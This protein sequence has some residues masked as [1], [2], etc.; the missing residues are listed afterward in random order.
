MLFFFILGF[1]GFLGFG[2]CSCLNSMVPHKFSLSLGCGA[3]SQRIASDSVLC[4]YLFWKKVVDGLAFALVFL[5]GM[6]MGEDAHRVF[7]FY[8]EILRYVCMALSYG[9]WKAVVNIFLEKESGLGVLELPSVQ[10]KLVQRWFSC[11][12]MHS[13]PLSVTLQQPEQINQS[14]CMT[15]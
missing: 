12:F 10:P 9:L 3:V 13:T 6:S 5:A 7:L 15:G 2:C 1:G 11:W 8:N 14:T 4:F